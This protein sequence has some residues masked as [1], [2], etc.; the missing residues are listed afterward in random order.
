[1]GKYNNYLEKYLDVIKMEDGTEL[2]VLKLI[3][4][5]QFLNK[6][7]YECECR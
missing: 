5:C 2:D 1:M 6:S 3:H 4:G 7:T